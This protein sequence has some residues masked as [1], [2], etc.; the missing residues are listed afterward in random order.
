VF[1]DDGI[2]PTLHANAS[3]S[4]AEVVEGETNVN[5]EGAIQEPDVQEVDAHTRL[6]ESYERSPG[7]G[8]KVCN[9]GTFSPRAET[10][11]RGMFGRDGEGGRRG[12]DGDGELDGGT[13]SWT[14]DIRRRFGAGVAER[15]RNGAWAKKLST[16]QV[17][18]RRHGVKNTRMMYVDS[19]FTIFTNWKS[20]G[21][22]LMMC[23]VSL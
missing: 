9:H 21:I 4:T 13:G 2:L 3:A 6:L 20:M 7:C 16:T 22:R 1:E 11:T 15:L 5:V 14:G 18:A 10:P 19:S 17:L 12:S 8:G 23:L